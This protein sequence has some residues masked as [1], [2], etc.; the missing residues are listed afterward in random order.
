MGATSNMNLAQSEMYPSV[1]IVD[2]PNRRIRGINPR[3]FSRYVV[4]ENN[5][6]T[7]TSG[8]MFGQRRNIIF[9]PGTVRLLT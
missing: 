1:S 6:A 4:K 2:A 9:S 5:F 8:A 3:D 7:F